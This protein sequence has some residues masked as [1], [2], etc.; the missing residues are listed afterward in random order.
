MSTACSRSSACRTSGCAPEISVR[1]SNT[2]G[3]LQQIYNPFTGAANG[4]DRQQFAN[5]QIPANMID[6]IALK[7]MQL[8]PLPNKPGIGAGGL[9]NNYRREETRTVDRKNFDVKL[10]F[11]RNTDHQIWTKFSMMDAVVDDLTNYLGPPTGCGR[12]R[13]VHAGSIRRPRDK[14]GRCR[15][16]C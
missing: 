1:R 16:R 3:S 15:R 11:N 10:N 6:P 12:R 2:N 7:I 5:N 9:T 8:Y 13:R 14:P 4:A